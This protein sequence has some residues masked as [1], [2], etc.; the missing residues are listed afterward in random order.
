MDITGINISSVFDNAYTSWDDYLNR[1]GYDERN[2]I[3]SPETAKMKEALA[4]KNVVWCHNKSCS[5]KT[6]TAIRLV[7]P[8]R[9][10]AIS[11]NTNAT[12]SDH[13]GGKPATNRLSYGVALE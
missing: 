9:K 5:G 4:A 11:S 8:N 12:C 3:D 6:Y 7:K 2:L 13:S 1:I 10:R